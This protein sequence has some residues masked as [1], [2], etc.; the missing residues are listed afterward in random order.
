MGLRRY[1]QS[2]LITLVLVM[3]NSS[4]RNPATG[5]SPEIPQNVKV[6][7]F[8]ALNIEVLGILIG[9]FV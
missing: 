2:R 6:A 5:P 4:P 1:S 7:C 3:D 8:P 9:G